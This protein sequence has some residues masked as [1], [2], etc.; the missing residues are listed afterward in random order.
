MKTEKTYVA[1]F[2]N[3]RRKNAKTT[4]E[5]PLPDMECSAKQAVWMQVNRTSDSKRPTF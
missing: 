4:E 3:P 1:N 5:I 2:Q